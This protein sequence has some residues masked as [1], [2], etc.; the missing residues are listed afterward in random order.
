MAGPSRYSVLMDSKSLAV[1]MPSHPGNTCL[2]GTG[3]LFTF[4]FSASALARRVHCVLR[5]YL[6]MEESTPSH[7]PW[8]DTDKDGAKIR[9]GD[10]TPPDFD[11][12]FGTHAR[13]C[14]HIP[15]S[16]AIYVYT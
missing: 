5:A 12:G 15:G 9:I 4:Y 14:W 11:V 8:P 16:V 2:P 13:Q 1:E 3:K 7:C 6:V 10:G